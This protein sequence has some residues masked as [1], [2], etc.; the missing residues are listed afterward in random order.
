MMYRTSNMGAWRDVSNWLLV[1]WLSSP[2]DAP[3]NEIYCFYTSCQ[4]LT[5]SWLRLSFYSPISFLSVTRT[6][7]LDTAEWSN[8][9]LFTLL[10]HWN[11]PVPL[12]VSSKEPYTSATSILLFF[13]K[14]TE[15]FFQ[16]L[17]LFKFWAVPA[18]ASADMSVGNMGASS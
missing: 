2:T 6:C 18:T 8:Y 10:K 5:C 7:S 17:L 9:V 12:N 11:T 4:I 14:N 13:K 3:N 16:L 1:L 15:V